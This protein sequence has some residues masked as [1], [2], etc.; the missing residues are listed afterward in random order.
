MRRKAAYTRD[1]STNP[2]R[3][4]VPIVAPVDEALHVRLHVASARIRNMHTSR[5]LLAQGNALVERVPH[6]VG[7]GIARRV[8]AAVDVPRGTRR[9]DPGGAIR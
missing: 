7:N 1:L 6:S 9:V 3:D 2:H 5:R 4:P 8:V